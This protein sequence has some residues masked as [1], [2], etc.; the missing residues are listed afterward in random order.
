MHRVSKRKIH[1]RNFGASAAIL[2]V[3]ALIAVNC[4]KDEINIQR[5]LNKDFESLMFAPQNNVEEPVII[6]IN[7]AS[8]HQLQ[9]LNGISQATADA[10]IEYRENNG[11]FKSVDEIINV[12][13]MGEKTLEK[14]RGSITV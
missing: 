6:N 13:G 9:R 4:L 11:G 5:M 2:A 8:A 14:I 1:L 12:K 10:V 3:F 7:T